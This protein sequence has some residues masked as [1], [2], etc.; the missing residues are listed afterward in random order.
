MNFRSYDGEGVFN[1]ASRVK[2][3][4]PGQLLRDVQRSGR[5]LSYIDIGNKQLSPTWA[6]EFDQSV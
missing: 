3:T 5:S 6:T 2:G 4:M 1:S